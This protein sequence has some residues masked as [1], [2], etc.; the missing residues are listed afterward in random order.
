MKVSIALAALVAAA[1]TSAA[2]VV[3]PHGNGGYG[4]GG[5]NKDK[6]AHKPLVNS[7][8]DHWTAGQS[9][10]AITDDIIEAA[11]EVDQGESS[12]QRRTKAS[13][14]GVCLP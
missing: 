1:T 4:H 12:P 7:V 8:G 3:N 6:C 9:L 2:A 11:P 14:P 5:G 10:D 13:R